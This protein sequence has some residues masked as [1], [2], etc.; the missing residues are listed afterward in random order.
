MKFSPVALLLTSA[1]VLAGCIRHEPANQP[2]A[3]HDHAAIVADSKPDSKAAPAM[4]AKTSATPAATAP[5][6]GPRVIEITVG[7]AL[8]FSLAHIE[9]KPGEELKIVLKHTGAL[10]KEAMGHNWVLLAKDADLETFGQEA[11]VA[12]PTDFIPP[13]WEAEI[14]AHTKLIG[15]GQTDTVTFA[16][17]K[18]PGDYTYLCTFPAHHLAGMRGVLTVK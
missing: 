2:A 18:A 12:K 15:A 6:A 9:A 13:G 8:K 10:P 1:L 7:D 5:A 17:P 4:P 16:A 11:A 14:L 3:A